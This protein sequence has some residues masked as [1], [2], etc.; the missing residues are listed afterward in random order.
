MNEHTNQWMI[1]WTKPDSS[2]TT[3][4]SDGS[5]G[6][7]TMLR[8]TLDPPDPLSNSLPLP[9]PPPHAWFFLSTFSLVL[10]IWTLVIDRLNKCNFSHVANGQKENF[11]SHDY[12]LTYWYRQC[13]AF[14]ISKVGREWSTNDRS[15]RISGERERAPEKPKGKT[16]LDFPVPTTKKRCVPSV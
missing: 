7:Q 3:R 4:T 14:G 16:I 12:S 13:P 15:E 5:F 2:K 1:E 9:P 8:K 10:F 6:L 11:Q